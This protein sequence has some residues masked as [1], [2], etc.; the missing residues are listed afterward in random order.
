MKNEFPHFYCNYNYGLQLFI[1]IVSMLIGGTIYTL[2]R[3]T[4]ASFFELFSILGIDEWISLVRENTVSASRYFPE[5]FVYSFPNG[6]W[7]F[8][9]SLFITC[10]WWKS[11]LLL[12]YFWWATIPFLVFGIEL[13]QYGGLLRG[14]FCLQDMAAG[15]LGIITGVITGIK[16]IKMYNY[17]KVIA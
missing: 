6:L 12:R 2:L 10:V 4:E 17:E 1:I 5:W 8:A 3:P 14:T 13:L 16:I 7:A 11:K 15:L 9:Y